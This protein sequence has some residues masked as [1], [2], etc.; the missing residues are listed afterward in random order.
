MPARYAETVALL[1]D[2]LR[3]DAVD[4]TRVRPVA[5]LAATL[6]FRHEMIQELT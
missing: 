2:T 1:A 4:H 6:T 3:A 5:E